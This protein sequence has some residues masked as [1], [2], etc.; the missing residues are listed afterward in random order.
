MKSMA[1]G[2]T[3][4]D[5]NVLIEILES[6]SKQGQAIGALRQT[7][8]KLYISTLTCHIVGYVCTKRLGLPLVEK[9]LADFNK[10]SLAPDDVAWAFA[11]ILGND[12]EDALQLAV[13]VRNGCR[14]FITLD[15]QLHRTYKDLTQIRIKLL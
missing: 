1:N 8:G 11:N 12:F 3:F 15:E 2:S 9:A 13:A 10:L 4:V 14:T 5:A 7:P 6:R